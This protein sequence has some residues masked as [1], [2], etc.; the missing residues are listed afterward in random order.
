MALLLVPPL[1][2]LLLSTTHILLLTTSLPPTPLPR[3]SSSASS[4]PN[5]ATP[6]P[7]PPPGPRLPHRQPH[8]RLLA[9]LRH[10]L[11]PRPPPPRR[12]LRR[13]RP[14]RPRRPRRPDLRRHRLLRP[15][16]RQPR[17]RHPPL[18]RHPGRPPVDHLR[19]RHDHQAQPGA[20][21]QQLQDHRRARRR[22]PHRRRRLRHPPVRLQR[23]HPQR[24]HPPLRPHRQ[25][26]RP[27]LP[28]PLRL[29]HRRGRRR[30]IHILRH[31]H[32]DR[33]LLPLPLHRRPH[34]RHHGLHQDHHLQQLLLPPQRGH[35]ARPQRQ[36]PAR[37]RNAGHHRLQPLREALVQRMPRCRR[38]TS[39]SSTRLHPVGD[40]RHRRERQPDHQQPGQPLHCSLRSQFQGSDEESGHGEGQWAGWN[41][42]TEG[43]LMVNGA[44]FV[45]SGEGL[46]AK[47]S[48]AE[49]LAPKT[50]AMIDQLTMNAGVFGGSRYELAS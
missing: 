25:R 47:Y 34:R 29:P 4:S 30:H 6:A 48:K 16:R 24:P 37:L 46:E 3:S 43:D 12:L 28:D 17:P 39:T 14:E 15:R 18:R 22:R 41:W 1:L 50:A 13:L 23:H 19:R 35:A 33:P 27:L 44:F 38:A 11:V 21:R 45:P 49:S 7:P 26:Q 10:R 9:L 42:R 8:R 5:S 36:L 20:P 32:L 31:R 2:L 40:V